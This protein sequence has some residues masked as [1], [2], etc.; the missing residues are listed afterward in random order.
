MQ[1]IYCAHSA[2]GNASLIVWSVLDKKG[3]TSW[4]DPGETPYLTAQ[5]ARIEQQ[6]RP[7]AATHATRLG[8]TPFTKHRHTTT[9]NGSE[10]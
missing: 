3:D 2:P 1:P 9:P 10:T 4:F 5:A 7:K 6:R 8:V